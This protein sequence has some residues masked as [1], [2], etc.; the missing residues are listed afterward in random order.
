LCNDEAVLN[1]KEP[2]IWK[3]SICTNLSPSTAL[4]VVREYAQNSGADVKTGGNR[5]VTARSGSRLTYRMFG[6]FAGP[7][8]YPL[9]WTATAEAKDGG[10]HVGISFASDEG[11]YLFRINA[12]KASCLQRFEMIARQIELALRNQRSS[13]SHR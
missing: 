8:R 9:H 7:Q 1:A 11:W 4:A 13:P 2:I 5:S 10:S 3:T 12:A 6:I